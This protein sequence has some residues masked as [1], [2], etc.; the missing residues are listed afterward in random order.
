VLSVRYFSGIPATFTRQEDYGLHLVSAKAWTRSASVAVVIAGLAGC[1]S[2]E[3]SPI[4]VPVPS[5]RGSPSNSAAP[6]RIVGSLPTGCGAIA[7]NKEIADAI[8]RAVGESAKLVTGAAD[9]GIGRTARIDCYYGIV[10]NQAVTEAPVAVG[11]AS[12]SD[13]QAAGRRVSTTVDQE[14]ASGSKASDVQVGPDKGT[15]LVGK[16][17]VTLVAAYQ[18]TTVVVTAQLEVVPAAQAPSMLTKIADRAL[19]PR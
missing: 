5:F 18:A 19:S 4:V 7:T 2:K 10:D 13:A 8:G 6:A 9:P 16:K 3:P 17:I 12:Y 1:A 11:L 15:L 14:K